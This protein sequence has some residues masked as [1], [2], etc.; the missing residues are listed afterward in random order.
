MSRTKSKKEKAI[1]YSCRSKMRSVVDWKKRLVIANKTIYDLARKT[2]IGS[3]RISEYVS[4]MVEP[5]DE[6]FFKIEEGLKDLERNSK[7]IWEQG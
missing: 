4:L 1:S 3:T 6:R 7:P 2:G 5:H